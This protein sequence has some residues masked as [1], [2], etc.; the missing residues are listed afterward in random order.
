MRPGHA[1]RI[2]FAITLELYIGDSGPGA[3]GSERSA[4]RTCDRKDWIIRN[5]QNN[6]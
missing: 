2:D 6:K 5:A 1:M 3:G 4:L